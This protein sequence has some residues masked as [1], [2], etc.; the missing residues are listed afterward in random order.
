LSTVKK[1]DILYYVEN[2]KILA[3][4][5]FNSLRR[6]VPDFDLQSKLMGM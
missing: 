3:E 2:G 4:G 6:K 5:D 1:S